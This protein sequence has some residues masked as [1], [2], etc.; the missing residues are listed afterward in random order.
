ME[1]QLKGKMLPGI[2][3]KMSSW[4]LQQESSVQHLWLMQELQ[5]NAL[6][7]IEEPFLLLYVCLLGLLEEGKSFPVHFEK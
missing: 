3:W 1:F 5:T 7:L 6:R 4:C 2:P